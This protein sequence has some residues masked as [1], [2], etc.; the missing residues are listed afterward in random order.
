MIT[1][2][3]ALLFIMLGIVS[4]VWSQDISASKT[5]SQTHLV[6]VKG[7]D[8]TPEFGEQFQKWSDNW[9]AVAKKADANLI[10]IG[11]S[12]ESD[13][14][15]QLQSALQAL[16]KDGAKPVW[17]VFIGH[18]TFSM[19]AAKFNLRGPDVSAKD[20]SDWLK[21]FTRP[22]V[23]ANC[24]SSSGPFINRLSAKNRVIVTATKSGSQYNYAR[25]G[26]YFAR[27]IASLDSDLD[28]DDAVSVQEAFLRASSDVQDFY[29]SEARLAT[30]HALIDDNGDARGTPAKMFRGVR[31]I[32]QAKDG[33]QL[34]GSFAAQLTLS[35]TGQQLPLTDAEL[36]RR[37]ELESQLNAI[38]NKKDDMSDAEFDEAIEPIL[39]ELAKIY[40]AAEKRAGATK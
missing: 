32:A 21:P 17:I 35:P 19:G 26:E 37:G 6:I 24:A 1:R 20:L 15:Q 31:A 40:Q 34:D 33:K 11:R 36:K 5:D 25:F 30:E 2:K 8:G 10:A 14:R 39:V 7:A 12:K 27:A 23:I 4:P 3:I 28:H 29:D 18:G 38:R 13:D 16:P 22:L 9:S